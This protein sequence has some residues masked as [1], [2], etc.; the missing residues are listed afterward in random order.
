MHLTIAAEM[1]LV[2]LKNCLLY[3]KIVENELLNRAKS[4]VKIRTRVPPCSRLSTSIYV[5]VRFDAFFMNRV[6]LLRYVTTMMAILF[7]LIKHPHRL[8]YTAQ[9][10]ILKHPTWT[11]SSVV[12]VLSKIDPD[13]LMLRFKGPIIC[14]IFFLVTCFA[15]K[16]YDKNWKLC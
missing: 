8:N 15:V 9:L 5:Y 16:S 12:F 2:L 11:Q 13:H 1:S 10:T 6:A 3:D 4:N 14:N 7:L